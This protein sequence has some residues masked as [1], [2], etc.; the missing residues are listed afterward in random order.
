[1][2]GS[3]K[4][5]TFAALLGA[6]KD[7][8]V[9]T[10]IDLQNKDRQGIENLYKKR[11]LAKKKVLTFADFA[12]KKEADIEDMFDVD[13]Y[14]YLVNQEFA[15][16]LASPV[17]KSVLKLKS[18]R[19]LVSLAEF[20]KNSPLEGNVHFN[21]YRPARL[22]AERATSSTKRLSEATLERFEKA[23]VALNGLLT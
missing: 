3:D 18:D 13:E 16:A 7:I 1:V 10:L 19:I 2:G 5:A 14:L 17:T 22:F 23:F 12:G 11:L 8:N 21:H 9:A 20:F 6:Q 4:I 15:A